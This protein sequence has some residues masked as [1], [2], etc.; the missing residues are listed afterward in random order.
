[1]VVISPYNIIAI[2][3]TFVP[4]EVR[5]IRF[6]LLGSTGLTV[7]IRTVAKI[8]RMRPCRLFLRPL[9]PPPP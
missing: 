1:M 3:I 7:M 5:Q 9:T 8:L 6:P 2:A 4:L